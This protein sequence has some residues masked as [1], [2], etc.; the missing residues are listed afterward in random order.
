MDQ[1][2]SLRYAGR[3]EMVLL[4]VCMCKYAEAEIGNGAIIR[5][6]AHEDFPASI[7]QRDSTSC[8][9]GSLDC[10]TFLSP[11]LSI[12]ILIEAIDD[13]TLCCRLTSYRSYYSLTRKDASPNR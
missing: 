12:P 7:S 5:V 2:V 3:K 10:Q 4:H 6:V 13:S 9:A 11:Y 8:A 1:I